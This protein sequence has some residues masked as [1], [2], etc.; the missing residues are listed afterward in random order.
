[1][2]QG[3]S[4]KRGVLSPLGLTS[5]YTFACLFHAKKHD[6][7]NELYTHFPLAFFSL[8]RP[9]RDNNIYTGRSLIG[10]ALPVSENG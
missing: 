3:L 9:I 7:D 6:G 8:V 1:M 5:Q 4:R 2:A 10:S